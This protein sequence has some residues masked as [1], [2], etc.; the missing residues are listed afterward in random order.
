MTDYIEVP[1]VLY[2]TALNRG[3]FRL[4]YDNGDR[5]RDLHWA[6]RQSPKGTFGI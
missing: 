1:R 3:M 5:P 2:W 4:A 6:W